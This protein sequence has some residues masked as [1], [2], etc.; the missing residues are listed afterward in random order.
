MGLLWDDLTLAVI[1]SS[2]LMVLILAGPLPTAFREAFED[3]R[4]QST[5]VATLVSTHL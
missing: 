1:I 5:K 4:E 2:P 3:L